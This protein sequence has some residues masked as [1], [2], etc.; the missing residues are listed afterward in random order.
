MIAQPSLWLL[1]AAPGSPSPPSST[2]DV[3]GFLG[4]KGW[5]WQVVPCSQA[6]GSVCGWQNGG[7]PHAAAGSPARHPG[8]I[9]GLTP[10]K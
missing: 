5:S 1:G 3:R 2:F 7:C 6:R 9:F 8:Q 4:R 10:P